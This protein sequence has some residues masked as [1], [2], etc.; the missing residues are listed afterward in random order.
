MT[1]RGS[2]AACMET[3]WYAAKGCNVRVS[4]VLR[5]AEVM[6]SEGS[7]VFFFGIHDG[8]VFF[9]RRQLGPCKNVMGLLLRLGAPWRYDGTI[10]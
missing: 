1:L 7:G 10:W 2:I 4:A 5:C 6:V 9:G 8:G 3:L